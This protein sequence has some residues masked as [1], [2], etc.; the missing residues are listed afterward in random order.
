MY[1][2]NSQSLIDMMI[3]EE[4][5][6]DVAKAVEILR[7]GGVV[8]YPTDT[9]WGIGCDATDDEAVRRIFAIKQRAEAKAMIT[10]VDG[11]PMLDRYTE[12]IPDVAEQ[13]IEEAVSPLT[14]VL[15]RPR[16]LAP[17]LLAPDG[18]AGFRVTS[19]EYSRELCRRL[20]KPVVS[21][22]ANISGSPT[23]RFFKEISQ[24]I[25][26]AMDYVSSYRRDDNQPR[27]SSSVIKISDDA[28]FQILRK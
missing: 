2:C 13:L 9:V 16:G 20:R 11:L 7:N 5:R 15:D 4:F 25:I 26:E 1:F 6:A 8:L 21:T 24:E 12:N 28:T 3:T 14:I 23:P 18:S 22:S 10:L 27:R 17:S 19:E